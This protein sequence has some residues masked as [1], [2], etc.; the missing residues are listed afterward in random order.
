[1]DNVGAG[2]EQCVECREVV[3]FRSVHYQRFRCIQC[4][5]S[6]AS[7]EINQV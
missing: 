7:V 5:V 3:H 1:M 2:G 6:K 4:M